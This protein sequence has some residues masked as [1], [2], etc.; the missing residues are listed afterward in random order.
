MS[1]DDILTIDQV[2]RRASEVVDGGA[3]VW[4]ESGA[5]EGVTT[6]RNAAALNRLGLVARLGRDV[7][8]IDLGTSFGGLNLD[9]PVFLA[10]VGALGLFDPDDGVAAGRAAAIARIPAMCATLTT[11]PWGDVAGTAPG[12][13][14]FQL[15]VLGD[16]AWQA[17]VVDTIETMGFGALCVTLDTPMIARR[18]RSIEAGS[19]WATPPGGTVNLAPGW[20]P[21]YRS[22]YSWA[23]LE[24][25]CGRTSLP[26]V[27]KGVMSVSDARIAVACGAAVVYV[28]N[29]GGRVLDHSVST[30]EVLPEIVDAVGVEVDIIIDSGFTRGAEICKALALGAKAVGLGRLQCWGLAIGGTDGLVRVLDILRQELTITLANLGCA[31]VTELGR[32]QVRWTIETSPPWH[33]IVDRTEGR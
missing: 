24:W 27:V 32:D 12:R 25:L 20:D 33:S 10:P 2:I 5:G 13:H 23:D 22:R 31:S 15:Y 18:D 6:A 17:D 7:S 21:S 30:I 14:V 29:H 19:G 28:S 3:M 26:V 11:S 1:L 4:T 16:R 8:A 9:L